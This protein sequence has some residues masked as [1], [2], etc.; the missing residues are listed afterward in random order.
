VHDVTQDREA[1]HIIAEWSQNLEQQVKAR[2]AELH[3]SQERFRQLVNA[4]FEGIVIIEDGKVVDGNHQI[5]TILGYELAEMIG[6]PVR[7]FVA[8]ES[9][10]MVARRIRESQVKVYELTGLRKDGT[11]VPLE[12]RPSLETWHG[13]TTRVTA[14]RDLTVSKQHAAS[15]H[16]QQAELERFHRLAM[17]SE[18]SAGMIHQIGQPLCSMG[19]NLQV[20]LNK[21][22]D[23]NTKDCGCLEVVTDIDDDV[24]RMREVIK[25]LRALSHPSKPTRRL[26]DYNKLVAETIDMLRQDALVRKIQLTVVLDD[27]LPPVS[28]DAVQ[29]S[30]VIINLVRNALDACDDC[31]VD[32]RQVT[33]TTRLS[34]GQG[35]ELTVCDAGVGLIPEACKQLFSPFFTTKHN[36]LGIGLRLS[37][38]ITKAHGGT[39]HGFNNATGIGATFQLVLPCDA[40]PDNVKV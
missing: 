30:Q 39:L 23:C 25:H 15:L 29:L 36:G 37:Q 19:V 16:A 35:V 27:E 4:T 24:G 38:T 18:I 17:V 22:K 6:R 21:L 12:C 14:L 3:H 9:R 10:S 20:A 1:A 8:P 7:D 11:T 13:T 32:R 28:A 26:I 33:I 5:A 2:T 40:L 31:P 34:I